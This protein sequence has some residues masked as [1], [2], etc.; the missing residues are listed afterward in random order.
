MAATKVSQCLLSLTLPGDWCLYPALSLNRAFSCCRESGYRKNVEGI[1]KV[2]LE[3]KGKM[4][5][6]HQL[7]E[8]KLGTAEHLLQK[9]NN[10]NKKTHK[11]V[12]TE[13][14]IWR[15]IGLYIFTITHFLLV[16]WWTLGLRNLFFLLSLFVNF[17]RPSVP[18]LL[19]Y[20]LINASSRKN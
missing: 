14:L 20:N 4:P 17:L 1:W 12:D 15:E 7:E 13:S 3:I 19:G 2:T 10:N 9:Q 18:P 8:K 5:Q 16:V 6:Q 11:L